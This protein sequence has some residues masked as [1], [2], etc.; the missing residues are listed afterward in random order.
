M[1]DGGGRVQTGGEEREK[2]REA[3]L[4]NG[5]VDAKERGREVER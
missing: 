1:G 2:R 3:V 5:R 4:Y